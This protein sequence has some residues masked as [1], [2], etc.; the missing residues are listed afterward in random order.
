MSTYPGPS[1]L[2]PTRRARHTSP[3]CP[4]A[5]G[6]PATGKIP[7]APTEDRDDVVGVGGEGAWCRGTPPM[8]PRNRATAADEA[9]E[10][11]RPSPVALG[12]NVRE[13]SYSDASPEAMARVDGGPSPPRRNPSIHP[14]NS[15]QPAPPPP[16]SNPDPDPSPNSRSSRS[17]GS[18]SAGTFPHHPS[19]A[20][21]TTASSSNDAAHASA[22]STDDDPS[23][24]A[25]QVPAIAG[26][27][28]IPGRNRFGDAPRRGDDTCNGGAI[29]LVVSATTAT[30]SPAPAETAARVAAAGPSR[31][32]R[33]APVSVGTFHFSGSSDAPAAFSP[34]SQGPDTASAP[35]SPPSAMIAPRVAS[36]SSRVRRHA[37]KS[38]S[39]HPPG[40]PPNARL[41]ISSSERISETPSET[42]ARPPSASSSP[43]PSPGR[44]TRVDTVGTGTTPKG[45]REASPTA[46]ETASSS[47]TLARPPR[48][49]RGGRTQPPADSTRARSARSSGVWSRVRRVPTWVGGR[50][51]GMVEAE[52]GRG[53][54]RMGSRRAH[55]MTRASPTWAIHARSPRTSAAAR[56]VP[57]GRPE[58]RNSASMRAM[59]SRIARSATRSSIAQAS[60][61]V[62]VSASST[63][64]CSRVAASSAA[65]SP[66]WPSNTAAHRSSEGGDAHAPRSTAQLARSSCRRRRPFTSACAHDAGSA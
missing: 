29:S 49:A 12:R 3:K 15:A 1:G 11:S 35:G 40:P 58:A 24:C 30:L 42:S 9:P 31:S 5:N 2:D 52:E 38:A 54:C 50:G 22:R 18:S 10:P 23:E 16:S 8:A 47:L 65:S 32:H 19:N 17:P 56:V 45:L 37:R 53:C 59:A 48:V 27:S 14:S 44:R 25:R 36:V 51:G 57:P 4:L 13:G 21:G 26:A 61:V 28:R 33:V 64:A 43:G 63:M 66:S 39:V 46:R 7:P 55:D 34:A 62:R 41:Q 60:R 6:R 20:G